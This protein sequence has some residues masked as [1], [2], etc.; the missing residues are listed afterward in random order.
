MLSRLEEILDAALQLSE[1][2]RLAIASRLLDTL[3]EDLADSSDDEA[4]L[5]TELERRAE[6][7]NGSIP[8]SE[9]WQGSK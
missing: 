9:L 6:D 8:L 1:T 7:R 3:P 4:A 2:D 5:I